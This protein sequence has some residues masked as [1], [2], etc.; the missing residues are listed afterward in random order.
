MVAAGYRKGA[1]KDG[2]FVFR[3]VML[4]SNAKKVAFTAYAFNSE[5]I[6]SATALLDYEVKTPATAVVKR[7]AFLLQVGVNHTTA[8]GCELKYSVNDAEVMSAALSEKLRVQG[9]ELVPMK[10]ESVA[11]ETTNTKAGPSATPQDD[12]FVGSASKD[13]IRAELKKIAAKATPDDVFFMSFS[14]HGFSAAGGAFYVLPSSLQGNCVHVDDA[15]LKTAISADELAEWLRPI[16]A[17]EMTL[18]LDACYS[19]ESVQAGDFKPGPMG[20]RGLGQVAYDKR[21]HVLAASQSDAV[22]HEYDYLH[23][24]LLSYVLVKDG[25]DKD[26][27]DWKP[28]DGKITVGEWLSYAAAAVPE[29]KPS[30]PSGENKGTTVA[31]TVTGAK[32]AG[33]VPALFDFSREDT[34]VL[35]K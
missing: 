26:K 22:A 25:L 19:A 4:K 28:K 24:G 34:L 30:A 23:Q 12:K 29:F 20:S 13:V 8:H 10:L 14:G 27:A 31:K 15:M 1:L 2:E 7:K 18:I 17:G 16:D 32:A 35:A 3:N 9:F 11:G 21:M 6:K 33:Q 5:R